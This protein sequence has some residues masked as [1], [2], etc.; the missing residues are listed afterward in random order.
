MDKFPFLSLFI[1]ANFG[2][3]PYLHTVWRQVGGMFKFEYNFFLARRLRFAIVCCSNDSP[4]TPPSNTSNFFA[5]T[6]PFWLTHFFH[7]KADNYVH[8]FVLEAWSGFAQSSK[9]TKPTNHNKVVT[10]S[11]AS[12]SFDGRTRSMFECSLVAYFFFKS[13]R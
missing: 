1:K 5:H 3:H 7:Y 4:T 11:H 9:T 10:W 12:H 6:D 2:Q 8:N 13:S